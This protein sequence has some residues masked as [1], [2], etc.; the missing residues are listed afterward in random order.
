MG[1]PIRHKDSEDWYPDRPA[2]MI[3]KFLGDSHLPYCSRATLRALLPA[4]KIYNR[5][6]LEANLRKKAKN[7]GSATKNRTTIDFQDA[8]RD[9]EERH[10]I[11]RGSAFVKVLNH[12][13]LREYA[14]RRHSLNESWKDYIAQAITRVREQVAVE[15]QPKIL[16]MR[17]AELRA[18]QRL[19]VDAR[20]ANW[21]GRG[22]V[23]FVPHGK[24]L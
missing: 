9:L 2:A 17:E 1:G 20:G 13:G 24:A 8:L 4:G 6:N 5:N 3:A 12:Q 10:L 22:S 21:S 11:E 19:M 18:L 15:R 23:R 7:G 16:E 14:A